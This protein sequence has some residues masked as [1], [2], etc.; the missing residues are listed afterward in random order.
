VNKAPQEKPGFNTKA[1]QLPRQLIAAVFTPFTRRYDVNL[2]TI[3]RYAEFLAKQGV[4]GVFVCGTT[5]E[6]LSL[7]IRERFDVAER[8]V[9]VCG[10]QM[11]VFIHVGNECQKD[12]C[13][14]AAHAQ[15]IGAGAIATIGPNFF[16]PRNLEELVDHSTAIAAAAPGLPFYYYHI[17]A[18][19]GLPYRMINFLTLAAGRIPTL[20]GIKFTHEDLMD[21]GLCSQ[22]KRGRFDMVFGRDEI[23]LSALALGAR[24]AIGST[25]NFF[26]PGY[27]K[28][29]KAFEEGDLA[30]AREEQLYA[31]KMIQI[32][33]RYGSIPAG[34]AI[35]AMRGI[36]CG[37]VRP[38]LTLSTSQ[39][40]ELKRDLE[41]IN[42]FDHVN[43]LRKR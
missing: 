34:K 31:M 32:L 10:D 27:L 11:R 42:F 23:L 4:A 39:A 40:G 12:A 21:F 24:K 20:A 22:F 18:M 36:D 5:G 43:T 29:T 13:A 1:T 33:C 28:I 14:L 19:T 16:K 15:E 38:P 37:P 25:Y 26:A 9:R 41:A 7:T 17:P 6:G 35:M 2:K 3:D 8:W 30:S